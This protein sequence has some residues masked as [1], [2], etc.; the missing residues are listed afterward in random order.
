MQDIIAELFYALLPYLLFGVLIQFVYFELS[1]IFRSQFKPKIA[2]SLTISFICGLII[3]L[4]ALQSSSGSEF[5]GI[6]AFALSPFIII[7]FALTGL[8]VGFLYRKRHVSLFKLLS[9]KS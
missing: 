2:H 9:K 8:P 6:L 5:G 7:S 1:L 3:I 4:L